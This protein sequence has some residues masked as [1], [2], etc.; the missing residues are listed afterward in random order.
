MREDYTEEGTT[1]LAGI[2]VCGFLGEGIVPTG[3]IE[4]SER[5]TTC[6]V[7]RIVVTGVDVKYCYANRDA[8]RQ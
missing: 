2:L 7:G 5:Y 4:V 8:R 3:E 6:W 1:E